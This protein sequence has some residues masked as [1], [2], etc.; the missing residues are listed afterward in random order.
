MTIIT[1]SSAEVC[2]PTSHPPGSLTAPSQVD[3]TGNHASFAAGAAEGTTPNI[4]YCQGYYFMV[5]TQLPMP[6]P[7]QDLPVHRGRKGRR[8]P[9]LIDLAA[10][11]Q[12]RQWQQQQQQLQEEQCR[13]AQ[14]LVDQWE[15]SCKQDETN[16]LP[17]VAAANAGHGAAGATGEKQVVHEGTSKQPTAKSCQN[18]GGGTQPQFKFCEY[19]GCRQ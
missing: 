6:M 7:V 3:L 5:P 15:Q 1:T 2:W 17:P 9:S 4:V 18:C 11:E 10:K 8:G 12:T 19:C 16:K 13:N 14:S